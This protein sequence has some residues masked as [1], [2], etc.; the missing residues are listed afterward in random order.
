MAAHV[1]TEKK[2]REEACK[3]AQLSDESAGMIPRELR[4]KL[5]RAKAAKGL[6]KDLEEQVRVFV[7]SWEDS[8]K[9][10]AKDEEP[11]IDSEDDEI[12]F[13][14]RNGQMNDTPPSPKVKTVEE[15]D[16]IERDRLVFESLANDQGAGFG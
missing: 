8:A 7:K 12:V 10:E 15:E 13:V 6:L 9:K 1:S 16:Q 3:K 11:E 14:G 2:K 5:K 4:E